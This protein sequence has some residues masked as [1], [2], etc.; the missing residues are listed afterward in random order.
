ML[1]I[2][3]LGALSFTFG[4]P[5][6]HSVPTRHGVPMVDYHAHIGDGITVDGAVA[7]AHRRG[8]RF[9]LL[10]HA[11]AKGQ[12]Y[13]VSDDEQLNAWIDSLEGKPCFKGIEAEG[14]DWLSAFSAQAIA[15]LDYVQSDPLG[16]PDR[17]GR[18]L[19]LWEP[20]FRCDNSQEFMDRYVNFHIE[21]ISR[22]IDILAVPTFLPAV[23]RADYERLWTPQRMRAV[24]EA[25]LKHNVA[26]EID[27][28]F[29]VPS[30]RFLTNAREAGVK[31][32]FGSNFQTAESMG[33]ISYC[34][35]MYGRL[36]LSLNQF[37]QPAQPGRKPIQIRQ[38]DCHVRGHTQSATGNLELPSA[39]PSRGG[40]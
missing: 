31:F 36:G 18:H 10:Q 30:F 17:S 20:G 6:D 16:M 27:C 39:G 24:I 8:V 1:L 12:G 21:Q 33:D 13:P 19:K 23:L 15:R 22:P 7:I 29:R 34:V 5:L 26:L 35:E 11:G 25:A 32:A 2:S 38:S 14:T 4:G 40:S 28:R 9:G 3:S 37:F